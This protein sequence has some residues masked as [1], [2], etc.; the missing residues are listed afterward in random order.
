MLIHHPCSLVWV[1]YFSFL[2]LFLEYYFLVCEYSKQT[3]FFVFGT[4]ISV[5]E[6]NPSIQVLF[7][8]GSSDLSCKLMLHVRV[9]MLSSTVTLTET[10]LHGNSRLSICQKSTHDLLESSAFLD[11][12][13]LLH[14]FGWPAIISAYAIDFTHP[15]MLTLIS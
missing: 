11:R 15:P 12:K 14:K 2:C 8:K 10:K 13:H 6:I 1:Q 9:F 4:W 7:S 5:N 3:F